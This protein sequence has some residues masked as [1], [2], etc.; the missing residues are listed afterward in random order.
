MS[1]P[2]RFVDD[3]SRDYRRRY[4]LPDP[5]VWDVA[6]WPRIDFDGYTRLALDALPDPPARVLDVGCGPGAGAARLVERGYAV[7]ASTTATERSGSL[8]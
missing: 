4:R 3:P 1:E 6:D 7:S 2:G 8:V 5:F